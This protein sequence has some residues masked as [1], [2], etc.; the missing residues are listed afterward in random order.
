MNEGST[1]RLS[2]DNTLL[3]LDNDPAAHTPTVV[4]LEHQIVSYCPPLAQKPPRAGGFLLHPASC[5]LPLA[6]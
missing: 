4:R 5:L 3:L 2:V 1:F 6:S